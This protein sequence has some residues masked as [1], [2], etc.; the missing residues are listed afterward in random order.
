MITASMN[1]LIIISTQ[2]KRP[3]LIKD[4]DAIIKSPNF[5]WR[6]I[7]TSKY[8]KLWREKHWQVCIL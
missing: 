3:F 6:R 1:K 4:V 8:L 5:R 7:F 2:L